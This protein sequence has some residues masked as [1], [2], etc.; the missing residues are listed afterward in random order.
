VHWVIQQAW[1]TAQPVKLFV[2]KDMYLVP[3]D[4][5]TTYY[6]RQPCYRKDDSA[7]R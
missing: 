4:F 2:D 6:T 1:A 7:M 3:M 5:V